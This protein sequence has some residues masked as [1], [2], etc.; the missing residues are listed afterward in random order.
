M[1]ERKEYQTKYRKMTR[2]PLI[3]V[4]KEGYCTR[5][6]NKLNLRNYATVYWYDGGRTHLEQST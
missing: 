5:Q 3:H 4:S 6:A 2:N 1:P